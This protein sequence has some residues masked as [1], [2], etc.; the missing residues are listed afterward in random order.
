MLTLTQSPNQFTPSTLGRPLE[1]RV[2]HDNLILQREQRTVYIFTI[3]GSGVA[4]GTAF[5]LRG[6]DFV[7]TPAGTYYTISGFDHSQSPYFRS[8]IYLANMLRQTAAF[9]GFTIR[10]ER[11]ERE[12]V[13]R[14]WKVYATIESDTLLGSGAP[15]DNDISGLAGISLAYQAGAEEQRAADRLYYQLHGP[16]GPIGPEHFAPFDQG[17]EATVDVRSIVAGLLEIEPPRMDAT[18]PYFDEGALGRFTLRYG[19][20]APGPLGQPA[21]FGRTYE[22]DA[23]P[24]I[25]ALFQ[26][27]EV[28]GMQPYGPNRAGY[29][30]YGL[31]QALLPWLTA[32]P[33]VRNVGKGS[34]EWTAIY[35]GEDARYGG[36]TTRRIAYRYYTDYAPDNPLEIFFDALELGV[37]VA[38]TG[39][40]IIEAVPDDSPF[41]TFYRDVTR[42]T[43]TVEQNLG[44]LFNAWAAESETISVNLSGH[45]CCEA[46]LYL[47]E[48]RGSWLTLPI[49]EVERNVSV[50]GIDYASPLQFDRDQGPLDGPYPFSQGGSGRQH[51]TGGAERFTL[52]TGLVR[53]KLARELE[54]VVA[55]ASGYLRWKD[56]N[57]G[58]KRLIKVGI[59][60]GE[61]PLYR[62][63]G[64][65]KLDITVTSLH[66]IFTR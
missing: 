58:R 17:A 26:P 60:T 66:E 24:V 61:L 25:A 49:E 42:Y 65:E 14:N 22:S 31:I 37:Y 33:Q 21:V 20:Y 47:L 2:R 45:G 19:T 29:N 36:G 18:T 15:A 8:A 46:E 54:S 13:D 9:R 10:T 57:T 7:T 40:Q 62:S 35:L 44:V 52:R 1:W 48:G 53:R 28:E 56:P 55:S 16:L 63:T 64:A 51:L 34:H 30:E 27:W 11:P 59:D 3:T 38:P 39:W 4:A 50:T 43:V 5:R 41:K 6:E 12:A 23:V 32:R